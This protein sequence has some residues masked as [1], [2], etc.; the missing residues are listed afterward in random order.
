MGLIVRL[1]VAEPRVHVTVD[2]TPDARANWHECNEVG[3]REC[4]RPAAVEPHDHLAGRRGHEGSEVLLPRPQRDVEVPRTL[5]PGDLR[6]VNGSRAKRVCADG[7]DTYLK[8][9]DLAG[10]PVAVPEVDD[11]HLVTC[12]KWPADKQ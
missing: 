5:E 8:L 12:R 10:Q 6:P 3:E 1:R 4:H 11:I 2:S 9:F 7:Q